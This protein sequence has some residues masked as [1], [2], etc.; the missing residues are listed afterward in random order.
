MPQGEFF[1]YLSYLS[2]GTLNCLINGEEG[3]KI[4]KWVG[5]LGKN[6]LGECG[7]RVKLSQKFDSGIMK[8]IFDPRLDSYP[9]VVLIVRP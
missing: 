3:S 7:W 8:A 4:F 5:W 2:L 1:Q 6:S 9:R